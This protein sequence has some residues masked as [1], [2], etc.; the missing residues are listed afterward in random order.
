MLV[1]PGE[2]DPTII[3]PRLEVGAAEQA[4]GIGSG[5]VRIRSWLETEDP[6]DLVGRSVAAGPGARLAVSDTLRAAFLLR[7]QAAFPDAAFEVASPV[8]GPLRR[9]KDAAEVALLRAA[10]HAADRA[11]MGLASGR[12][13]DRSEADVAAEVRARLAAEGHDSASFW[14]VASGPRSASP[15]HEPDDR[16]IRAGEPLLLDIGGRL[17]GYCSDITRTLW[18]AGADGSGPDDEFRTIH[19]LVL[20]ANEAGREAVRPGAPAQELDRAARAVIDT[21][22]YGAAF[23]HRLGHGIGVEGHE[24]PYLVEG[25]TAPLVVGDAFSIEPGIYLEGRYGVRIEDIV[26]CTG[27]GADVL[28]EAPRQLLVVSGL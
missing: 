20:A 9:A 13:V 21:A 28:N 17:G 4:P 23:F 10:A 6:V 18:V 8:V 7:L 27:T 5:G 2:G 1:V 15:H 3:T 12:L 16:S 24:D 25:N 11:V 22:G 19:G 26:V 14:I